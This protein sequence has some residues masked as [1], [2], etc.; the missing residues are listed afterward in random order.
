MN[1]KFLFNISYCWKFL[2]LLTALLIFNSCAS[3]LPPGGGE[4]DKTPPEIIGVFPQNGSTDYKDDFFE[5]IFSEY[6]DK[7]SVQEAIFISPP[8]NKSL[9]Y[10][11]SGKRLSVFFQ[12][13]LKENTTYTVTLGAEV[14]DLNNQNKMIEPFTFAFSTG[15]TIDSGKIAGKIYDV[16]PGGIM[17]Y[18]YVKNDHEVD[19]S[20]R[21]P[22]Y[23]S[24]VG[25]NGK[26]ILMGLS[27]GEYR[28]Y[29]LRDNLRDF[30]YQSNEDQFGVQF[31][32]LK[33]S[34]EQNVITNCDFLMSREDTIPPKISSV[35][36]RDR[37]HFLIEFSEPVDSTNILNTNFFVY[38][39]TLQKQYNIKYFF[40]GDSRPGQYFLS[41]SDSLVNGNKIYLTVNS[42]YDRTGNI[43]PSESISITPKA[44]PDTIPPKIRKIAGSMPGE[45]VDF[46]NPVINIKFDDGFSR[47]GIESAIII[48]DGNG[49]LLPVEIGFI[50]DASFD[51]RIKSKLQQR[52]DYLLKLDLNK[53]IDAAGNTTDSL[54]IHKFTTNSELDFSGAAGVVSGI[55]DPS[56]VYVELK[57]IESGS[58]TYIKKIGKDKSF[59]VD[60]IVPGKYLLNSFIDKNKNGKYD[61]GKVRQF[62]Y[63]EKFTFYPDTLNLRARWPVVDLIL[64]Y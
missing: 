53:F 61:H 27:E 45:K 2:P 10:D 14:A 33:L 23:I 54:H 19:P 59:N 30:L 18:A 42:I 49:I 1:M 40:K 11:W 52:K 8:L 44:D 46:I 7:R 39:S 51:V 31:K 41:I 24:Q 60:R 63:A 62:K 15:G 5:L 38:D 35:V 64:D 34:G 4:I 9:I 12:D 57:S 32:D 47:A 36:M 26:F 13:T 25:K 48:E 55:N 43:N 56:D 29:A 6:V 22:D 58:N 17:V 50:D 20:V 16:D 28:V 3:Q 21:K 37:N